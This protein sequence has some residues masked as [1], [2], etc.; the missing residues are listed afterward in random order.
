MVCTRRKYS[1]V[2]TKLK[3]ASTLP[4]SILHKHIQQTADI[5]E[6]SVLHDNLKFLESVLVIKVLRIASPNEA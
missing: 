4:Q 6:E 2:Q 5:L 1:S 3:K